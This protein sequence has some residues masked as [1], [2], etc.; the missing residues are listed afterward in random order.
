MC[1]VCVKI[2][3]TFERRHIDFITLPYN[4]ISAFQKMKIKNF[5]AEISA[6]I[7]IFFLCR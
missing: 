2:A 3:A 6:S 1:T 5:K 7:K 4:N